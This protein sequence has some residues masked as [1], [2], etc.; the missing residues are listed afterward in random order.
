MEHCGI[1]FSSWSLNSCCRCFVFCGLLFTLGCATTAQDN[2]VYTKDGVQY[3]VTKS[4][5]RKQWWSYYERGRS[6]QEGGF[7]QE[8]ESDFRQ[9]LLRRDTDQRWARTYGLHFLRDYFPKRELGISLLYQD[10]VDNAV[11]LLTNSLQDERSARAELFLTNAREEQIS[12]RGSDRSDPTFVLEFPDLAA[13]QANRQITIRGSAHDDTFLR[14]IVIDGVDYDFDVPL[15]DVPHTV[16][17][18]RDVSLHDGENLVEVELT[19]IAGNQ[20]RSEI[21]ITSDQV[22]PTISFDESHRDSGIIRGVAYDVSGVQSVAIDGIPC[23]LTRQSPEVAEF[24]VPV[25]GRP[26]LGP[27][28]YEAIDSLGNIASGVM[29]AEFTKSASRLGSLGVADTPVFA[30]WPSALDEWK[31]APARTRI[32]FASLEAAETDGPTITFKNVQ[33]GDK[34]YLE[35]LLVQLE[36]RSP[37]AISSLTVDG[38][39]IDHKGLIGVAT[40]AHAV[41]LSDPGIRTLTAR[42]VD[43]N[44]KGTEQ[45]VS[46]VREIP[47]IDLPENR[48]KLIIFMVDAEDATKEIET[49]LRDLIREQLYIALEESKRFGLVKPSDL[50]R[51]ESELREAH[52]LG[53]LD[54]I[55]SVDLVAYVSI[56]QSQ[57]LEALIEFNDAEDISICEIDVQKGSDSMQD[58]KDL[59]VDIAR[60]A[61][62]EFVRATGRV[63]AP[64]RGGQLPTDLTKDQ[65][66]Q[67]GTWCLVYRTG[68]EIWDDIANVSRGA[69]FPV[70]AEGQIATFQGSVSTLR[71]RADEGELPELD[72]RQHRVT[73]K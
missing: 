42:I 56:R 44:G 57:G 14:R 34:T 41:K 13:V 59:C 18:T 5:F 47:E 45:S 23:A 43:V 62:K 29:P 28:R 39:E 26:T 49:G 7:Y 72:P 36:V 70:V 73:T 55:T 4:A 11:E 15:T 52:E 38:K 1:R 32:A 20:S 12:R 46:V 19:D 3:G 60:E 67:R 27:S 58:I 35:D 66:V 25:H 54:Q 63:V 37:Q 17:V 10:K 40:T 22:G 6:F 65:G 51:S 68:D 69:P 50:R 64:A 16:E 30:S 21:S 9:A 2:E 61:A 31:Y 53:S 8:A 33:E 71:L 24:E 48:L